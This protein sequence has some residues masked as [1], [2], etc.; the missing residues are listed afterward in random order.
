MFPTALKA[1]AMLVLPATAFFAGAALMTGLSGRAIVTRQLAA[2]PEGDRVPLNSRLRYDRAAVERHW[3]ALDPKAHGPEALAAET[4][5]LEIDLV[6][7]LVYGAAFLAAL[8][9]GWAMLGRTFN[10]TWLVLAV[11]I[12]LLSDWTEN[13]TMLGQIEA[14]AARA[15]LS[16]GRIALA[17]A[18]TLVK[19][20][21]VGTL[22]VLTIGEFVL[23]VRTMLRA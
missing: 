7:P 9:L 5:F 13:L 14:Y 23:V 6:F 10:P 16:D 17:S 21:A 19:L 12:A 2:L 1:A 15:A 22:V 8:L 11:G 4:R 20:L 3:N 18:A